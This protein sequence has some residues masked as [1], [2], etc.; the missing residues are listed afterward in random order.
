MALKKRRIDKAP[1]SIYTRSS[2]TSAPTHMR[3]GAFCF[4]ILFQQPQKRRLEP[5]SK[6]IRKGY[7]TPKS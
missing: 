5:F 2:L 1:D 6:H 7:Q 3:C 4:G